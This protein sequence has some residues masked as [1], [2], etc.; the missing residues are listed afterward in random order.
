MPIIVPALTPMQYSRASLTA[1]D[2]SAYFTA[3]FCMKEADILPVIRLH[4][5]A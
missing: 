2:A 4:L 3:L 1:Y 5:C